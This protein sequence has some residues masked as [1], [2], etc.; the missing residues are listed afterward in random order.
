MYLPK[1]LHNNK[2][3]AWDNNQD[4]N[5]LKLIINFRWYSQNIFWSRRDGRN[6]AEHVCRK[7]RS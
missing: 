4:K 1:S 6:S 7:R 3:T 2:L 5:K